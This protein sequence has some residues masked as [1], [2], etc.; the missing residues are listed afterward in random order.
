MHW[1]EGSHIEAWWQN[2]SNDTD[3]RIP[4]IVLGATSSSNLLVCRGDTGDLTVVPMEKVKL[5]WRYDF[6]N[7][8]WVDLDHPEE[9]VVGDEADGQG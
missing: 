4:V 2:S 1:I 5:G 9:A 6:E 3:P 8:T 7:R